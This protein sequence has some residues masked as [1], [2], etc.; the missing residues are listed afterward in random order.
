VAEKHILSSG[1][2]K[3]RKVLPPVTAKIVFD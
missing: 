1:Y 2:M 3:P